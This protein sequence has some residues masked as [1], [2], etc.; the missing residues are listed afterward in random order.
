MRR[1]L[2]GSQVPGYQKTIFC[3]LLLSSIGFGFLSGT[4]GV[5]VRFIC[6]L[7]L[8][9]SDTLDNKKTLGIEKRKF[10]IL[11]IFF[12]F[13]I[14]TYRD[15]NIFG[16]LVPIIDTFCFYSVLHL[17]E[18]SFT[19]L[20]K[21]YVTVFTWISLISLIAWILFLFDIVLFSPRPIKY[22][23]IYDFLDYGFFYKNERTFGLRFQSLF[24]EPGMYGI[25][26]IF[27]IILNKLKRDYKMLIMIACIIFTMSLASY[28]LLFVL[29]LYYTL[30]IKKSLISFFVVASMIGLVYYEGL[31]YNGGDNIIYDVVFW[32]LTEREDG[33]NAFDD[34]STYEVYQYYDNMPFS[35]K[36]MGIGGI[37]YQNK[38]FEGS[39]DWKSYIVRDGY[40][41]LFLFTILL[42]LISRY[43]NTGQRSE[44]FLLLLLYGLVFYRGFV[45][46]L[47][48]G[49]LILF[50]FM[51]SS[52]IL[53]KKKN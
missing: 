50:Y 28:I 43:K 46:A 22:L 39:V 15:S 10:L 25:L 17:K 32:R 30:A 1:V 31:N 9:I 24:V 26:C 47:N 33:T 45:F 11:L 36:I 35:S 40:I 5:A 19:Q 29:F 53:D 6:A 21:T 49:A 52:R 3:L 7:L 2:D 23:D 41:G 16:F 4:V 13:R 51:N 20:S 18:T 27:T 34:R 12:V 37:Q 8:L 48:L 44:K 38:R 42:L 14:W